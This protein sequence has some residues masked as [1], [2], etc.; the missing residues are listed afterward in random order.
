MW[1]IT[2]LFSKTLYLTSNFRNCG[3]VIPFSKRK[4]G[5]YT[6]FGVANNTLC[7]NYDFFYMR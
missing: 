6:V 5:D 3:G 1:E 2:T 4:S 7:G